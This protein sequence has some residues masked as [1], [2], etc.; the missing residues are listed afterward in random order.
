MDLPNL[1]CRF[2]AYRNIAVQDAHAAEE[3]NSLCG[4]EGTT[5][6][7]NTTSTTLATYVSQ[8]PSTLVEGKLWAV[9]V[10]SR[11]AIVGFTERAWATNVKEI[12]FTRPLA[13]CSTLLADARGAGD[14]T[15]LAKATDIH[16]TLTAAKFF[17]KGYKIMA[18]EKTSW[19]DCSRWHLT[20]RRFVLI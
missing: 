13:M 4:G 17:V 2:P 5:R 7:S 16:E 14:S 1:E 11:T 6:T 12:T 18:R 15:V 9:V 3:V 10:E 8:T 20:R 19:R